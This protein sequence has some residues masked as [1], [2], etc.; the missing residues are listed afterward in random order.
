MNQM[1]INA[2]QRSIQRLRISNSLRASKVLPTTDQID[3][4]ITNNPTATS[5]LAIILLCR[6]DDFIKQMYKDGFKDPNVFSDIDVIRS[7]PS[8]ITKESILN[9]IVEVYSQAHK[10]LSEKAE[11]NPIIKEYLLSIS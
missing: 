9:K 4:E 8:S 10:N 7:L 2:Y 11:A 1:L 6:N 3:I 5:N